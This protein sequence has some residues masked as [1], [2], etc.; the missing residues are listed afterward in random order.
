MGYKLNVYSM[1]ILKDIN[2]GESGFI[3]I[4]PSNSSARGNNILTKEM[5]II[6]NNAYFFNKLS[7]IKRYILLSN[8]TFF[9]LGITRIGKGLEEND[10]VLDFSYFDESKTIGFT[11]SEISN[12]DLKILVNTGGYICFKNIKINYEI[13]STNEFLNRK[14]KNILYRTKKKFSHIYDDKRSRTRDVLSEINIKSDSI[15]ILGKAMSYA[16]E[17]EDYETASLIRDEIEGRKK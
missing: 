7:N 6:N 2:L 3:L 4:N 16:V 14:K 11:I 5:L 13:L 9:I 15:N 8:N 17:N 10:F 12:N 1:K